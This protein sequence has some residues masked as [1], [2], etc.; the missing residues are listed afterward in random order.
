MHVNYNLLG[1]G[2]ETYTLWSYCLRHFR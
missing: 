1:M 2:Q